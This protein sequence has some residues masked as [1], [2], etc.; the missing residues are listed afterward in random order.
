MSKVENVYKAVICVP[1]GKVLTYL[2]SFDEKGIKLCYDVENALKF[3]DC[4]EAEKVFDLIEA[5]DNAWIEEIE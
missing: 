5:P 4:D 3:D 1:F 2:E